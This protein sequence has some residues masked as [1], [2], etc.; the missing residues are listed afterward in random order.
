MTCSGAVI[1]RAADFYEMEAFMNK[2]FIFEY[3]AEHKLCENA[4]Q[5]ILKNAD[6]IEKSGCEEEFD[7]AGRILF[8]SAAE[9]P[10]E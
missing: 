8:D 9:N 7:R 3:A 4:L 5:C 10:E 1:C 6:I 2:K